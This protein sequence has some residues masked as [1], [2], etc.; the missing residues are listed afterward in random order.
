MEELKLVD[1]GAL[2]AWSVSS[3]K[4]GS[5]IKELREDNPES[6]WQSDG[7]QPH[8]LDIHFSKKFRS[9]EYLYSQTLLVMNH[10]HRPKS[11][12]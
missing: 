3:C 12:S 10:I 4:V 9:L 11:H 1:I 6:F 2:G 7:A 5:G 8:Y